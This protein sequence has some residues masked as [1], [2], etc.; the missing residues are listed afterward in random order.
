M[1]SSRTAAELTRQLAE[2]TGDLSAPPQR[3][4]QLER[5]RRLIARSGLSDA[6]ST[7][8]HTQPA[9][10]P[11]AEMRLMAFEAAA[12]TDE[13][14][15]GIRV[16]RREDSIAPKGVAE[17]LGPFFSPERRRVWFDVFKDAV[18]S[19]TTVSAGVG[20]FLIFTGAITSADGLTYDVPAG[21]VWVAAAA[22]IPGAFAQRYIGLLVTSGK[23]TLSSPTF[24]A[25]TQIT[26]GAAT[27]SVL[28][29]AIE[30]P[31][32]TPYFTPPSSVRIDFTGG[33]STA[34]Q[35]ATARISLNGA[36]IDLD[37]TEP[38]SLSPDG[39]FLQFGGATTI[40][41]AT[42]ASDSE[43]I[44][45]A[46]EWQIGSTHWVFN[47][48]SQDVVTLPTNS[49]LG[50]IQAGA[51]VALS[52]RGAGGSLA[53]NA[54][55]LQ[56][57]TD[58]FAITAHSSTRGVR[59]Q[60]VDAGEVIGNF[61]FDTAF[62]LFIVG[63]AQPPE[64]RLI[65]HAA[66][67]LTARRPLT[68]DG[69]P[70]RVSSP[71]ADFL[72]IDSGGAV[73][74]SIQVQPKTYRTAL[75][76]SNAL[77]TVE[78]PMTA[79]FQCG[80]DADAGVASGQFF[81]T[82][83]LRGTLPILPDPYVANFEPQPL[84]GVNAQ[85][86][87][88]ATWSANEV[89]AVSIDLGEPN[90]QA[91]ALQN[92]LPQPL[93]DQLVFGGTH[94][95]R[96]VIARFAGRISP[97]HWLLDVST[98]A[99]Q[100]GVAFAGHRDSPQ[101]SIDSSSL[102]WYGLDTLV[103]SAPSIQW[104]PVADSTGL[105]LTTDDGGPSV[106]AINSVRLV[107]VTPADV[108][109][110]FVEDW[111]RGASGRASITLP[112]GIRATIELNNRDQG[113]PAQQFLPKITLDEPK[114]VDLQSPSRLRFE[115]PSGFGMPGNT[116]QT[117][118]IFQA[119]TNTN[120]LGKLI[121]DMFNNSFQN[122]VPLNLYD[123]SGFG[124]S[125]F[126][127]WVNPAII[128]PNVSQIQFEVL[129]GRCAHEV[130]QVSA[131]LW[132]CQAIVVRTIT[133]ER[134]NN[135]SV[136]KHDSGWIA[137]TDGRFTYAGTKCIFHAGLAGGYTRI[138]EIRDTPRIVQTAG[139]AQLQQVFFDADLEI[140]GVIGGNR[141]AG[142]P[143]QRHAGYVHFLPIGTDLLPADLQDL[144]R[145]EGPI[146]GQ[147]DCEIDV[148]GSGTR[149]QISKLLCETTIRPPGAP[150]F[151]VSLNGMPQFPKTGDWTAVRTIIGQ[152]SA[153]DL[154]KGVPVI[155]QAG[156]PWRFSEPA[157]LFN[158]ATPGTKYGFLFSTGSSRLLMPC[159]EV[160]IGDRTISS[161]FK[162]LMADPCA[163]A[164]ANGL[165]PKA[166]ASLE[167]P[168]PYTLDFDAPSI[169]DQT[170]AKRPAEL[171]LVAN[172]VMR[173][174]VEGNT[175]FDAAINA[176][177]W[178]TASADQTL[179]LDLLG[180]VKLLSVTGK[181][182]ADS[183]GAKK[184]RDPVM[185][186]SDQ[187]DQVKEILDLLNNLKLP[188]DMDFSLKIEGAGTLALEASME[189]QLAE[190]DGNRIDTGMGKLSG[191]LRLGVIVRA[192]I[193]NGVQGYAFLE[194]S[195]D[196]QQAIIPGLLYAG[197]HLRFRAG[198]FD[199]GDIQ[200]EF[201]AGTVGSIGGDLIKGLIEV[202]GTAKYGYS[203]VVPTNNLE[204]I[205]FGLMIGMEVRATLLSGLVGIKF[206]WE[207][208]ALMSLDAPKTHVI[209]TAYVSA[210]ASVT[211]AWVFKTKRSVNLEYT[212]EV[213]RGVVLAVLA[214]TTFGA[215]AAAG[216]ALL[217]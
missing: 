98:N 70:I 44:Q 194:I 204:Q 64:S 207:G 3:L 111:Q 6:A 125:S 16:V 209:I 17:T 26:I 152:T 20:S 91:L 127:H 146:G 103:F 116:I 187:L 12:A 171:V 120:V 39:F 48:E 14:Q 115:S 65:A 177:D 155:G 169:F 42:A 71:S 82:F 138:R 72:L 129:N 97:T 58:S 61:G 161:K 36:V 214:V 147:V 33:S 191:M 96:L 38:A 7:R 143:V 159:P 69:L 208:G 202:E 185:T 166:E 131:R 180:Y 67:E 92:S 183:D 15:P 136:V 9:A 160:A 101:A 150:E 60:L 88:G 205:R 170:A 62:P 216:P 193:S 78:G 176:V 35:A 135:A 76:V 122:L 109:K 52:W 30:Q 206:G 75:A 118:N 189:G 23:L 123:W 73:H 51:G 144:L 56:A 79:T 175:P 49:G 18:L 28:E 27:T 145:Q 110:V 19:P 10:A 66:V 84:P 137:S 32:G 106:F 80:L 148:G 210:S 126:S 213:P 114:I 89:P 5:V 63:K 132:P 81:C 142:V 107:P 186:L 139:G 179:F 40:V 203:M 217:A 164:T 154:G 87:A 200:L 50:L 34:F 1:G 83:A 211:A 21:G 130:V 11:T 157:D 53:L 24:I 192:S 124:A 94:S 105:L 151:V 153:V 2:L 100:F 47:P 181:W 77:L 68:A 45:F 112:F 182:A 168:A 172:K 54:V 74:L 167:F 22:L 102:Q 4:E 212:A 184:F 197:G 141:G 25:G 37:P 128:P 215:G 104:E 201:T 199:N 99:G 165:F 90:A 162:A 190:P 188:F 133:I 59:Q 57:D 86:V 31:A 46:G 173:L 108:T 174:Y 196:L 163:F 119:G 29:L 121:G 195:G 158:R 113:F 156:E 85:V 134:E 95:P 149:M 178:K 41:S 43:S 93:D 8:Q 140:Q 117:D 13:A 55:T 198:V